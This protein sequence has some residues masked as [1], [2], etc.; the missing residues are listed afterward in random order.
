MSENQYNILALWE[1]IIDGEIT[2]QWCTKHDEPYMWCVCRNN[3]W[4]VDID[5]DVMI[6]NILRIYL[7]E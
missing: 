1:D 4:A 6:D 2:E 3:T 5:E 7:E